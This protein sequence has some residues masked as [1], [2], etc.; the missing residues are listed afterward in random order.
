MMPT[1]NPARSLANRRR[2]SLRYD[3]Q[4]QGR[5]GA[6]QN[7]R[8][9]VLGRSHNLGGMPNQNV[10]AVAIAGLHHG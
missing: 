5:A 7:A 9:P 1:G 6:R 3:L 10:S 2:A 4:L 8:S